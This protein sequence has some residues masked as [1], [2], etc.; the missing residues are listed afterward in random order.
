MNERIECSLLI[1]M[2]GILCYY[3]GK[4]NWCIRYHNVSMLVTTDK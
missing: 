1:V 3:D 2:F 4:T